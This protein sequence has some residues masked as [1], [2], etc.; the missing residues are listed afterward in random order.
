MTEMCHGAQK[1]G[2]IL[3]SII[4]EAY[5][6]DCMNHLHNVWF[7]GVEKS[8]TKNLNGLLCSSLDEIDSNL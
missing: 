4:E 7:G 6:L 8:I 5:N 3:V 2:R 1:L